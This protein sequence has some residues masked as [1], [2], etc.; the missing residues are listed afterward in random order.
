MFLAF[1]QIHCLSIKCRL[2]DADFAVDKVLDLI[3]TQLASLVLVVH[4]EYQEILMRRFLDFLVDGCM[5]LLR[6]IKGLHVQTTVNIAVLFGE[7]FDA[8][9]ASSPVQ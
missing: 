2:P 3:K 1:E 9:A 5:I 4:L 7:L 8:L 6:P